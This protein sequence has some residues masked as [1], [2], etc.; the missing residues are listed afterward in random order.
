MFDYCT[1]NMEWIS[2]RSGYPLLLLLRPVRFAQSHV[3][4][5]P[6]CHDFVSRRSLFRDAS[7]RRDQRDVVITAKEEWYRVPLLDRG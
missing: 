2:I 1:C 3:N 5:S 4:V 7:R 6:R